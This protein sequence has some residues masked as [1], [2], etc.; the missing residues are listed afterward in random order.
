[1][2]MFLIMNPGSHGGK[3]GR[4]FNSIFEAL[5]R[6]DVQH[7][8]RI[9]TTLDEIT[10]A[11]ANACREGY[12]P[13]ISVG[14]DG[15]I[16]RVVNGFYDA[17]G[18]LIS[19]CRLGVIY[20]GTSPDFCRSYRLPLESAAAL[21]L[22]LRSSN[23]AA[24]PDQSVVTRKIPLG[25]IELAPEKGSNDTT[26]NTRYFCCCANI[27]LGARV[28][29]LA[30]GGIRRITGDQLGTFLALLRAVAGSREVDL[31]LRRDGQRQQLGSV[32]NLSVGL[33]RY[34]ASG[35]KVAHQLADS[36]DRF[37]TLAASHLT[38]R[39]LPT[40]LRDLYRGD[41]LTSDCL[42]LDYARE[43]EISCATTP[44]EVE[45]DGDP[46]GYLPCT[47]SLARERL[48]LIGSQHGN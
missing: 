32:R 15:T 30:N 42:E 39:A 48:P 26:R 12:D 34:I 29:T 21:A 47:I 22:I 5:R 33:T 28:A 6:H 3:S 38:L 10:P 27:G 11:T 4:L 41:T 2:S 19:S 16:N 35:I 14:G 9:T 18:A 23:Q 31:E 25:R 17:D 43:L 20:T 40:V 24:E 7:H 37:Y 46:A 36:D 44:V 8:Y 13:V 45:F 1:M